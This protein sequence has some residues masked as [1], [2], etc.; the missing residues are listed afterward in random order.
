M[1]CVSLLHVQYSSIPPPPIGQDRQPGT[2]PHYHLID[3]FSLVGR[4]KKRHRMNFRLPFIILT[5]AY[6]FFFCSRKSYVGSYLI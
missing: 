5:G 3:T 2:G 4:G 1:P 6:F